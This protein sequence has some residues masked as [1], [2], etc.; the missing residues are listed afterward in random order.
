MP[1]N[2]KKNLLSLVTPWLDNVCKIKTKMLQCVV[3]LKFFGTKQGLRASA[4]VFKSL[5]IWSLE[6]ILLAFNDN[7]QIASLGSR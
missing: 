6:R 5:A 4:M 3:F 1:V 7:L 2:R